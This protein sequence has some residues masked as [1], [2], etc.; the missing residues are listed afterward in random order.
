MVRKRSNRKCFI[1]LINIR[2]MIYAMLWKRRKAYDVYV[3]CGKSGVGKTS[4]VKYV[5]KDKFVKYNVL[6]FIDILVLWA[7]TGS[8]SIPNEEIIIIEDIDIMLN[9]MTTVEYCNVLLESW[10]G[11]GTKLILLTTSYNDIKNLQA[12]QILLK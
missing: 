6:E 10:C 3:I 2:A 1:K 12:K 4:Y 7:R 8:V 11:S 5:G 9:K